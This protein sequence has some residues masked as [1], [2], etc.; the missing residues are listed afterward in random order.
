MKKERKKETEKVIYNKQRRKETAEE[1]VKS[2]SQKENIVSL[3]K[4]YDIS[5]LF[6]DLQQMIQCM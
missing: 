6:I 4:F 1:S 2:E 5:F 3:P